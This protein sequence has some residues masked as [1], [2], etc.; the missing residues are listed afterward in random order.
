MSADR[1]KGGNG[2]GA[3]IKHMVKTKNKKNAPDRQVTEVVVDFDRK[4]I[5]EKSKQTDENL[6][7][8]LKIFDYRQN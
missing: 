6:L 3:F 7:I 8:S 1:K 2:R 5:C 4:E